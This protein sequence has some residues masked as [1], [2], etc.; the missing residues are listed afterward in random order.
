MGKEEIY[1]EK[2][3]SGKAFIGL[4]SNLISRLVIFRKGEK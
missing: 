2:E 4:E 1:I 3:L